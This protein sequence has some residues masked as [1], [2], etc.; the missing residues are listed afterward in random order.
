ML[1][2]PGVLVYPVGP[3]EIPGHGREIVPGCLR[4]SVAELLKEFQKNPK[5]S[6]PPI[7]DRAFIVGGKGT[8]PPPPSLTIS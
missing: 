5:V 4:I 8:K 2:K 3:R 6:L 1:T 7:A